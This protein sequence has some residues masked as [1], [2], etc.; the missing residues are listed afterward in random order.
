MAILSRIRELPQTRLDL[1]DWNAHLSSLRTDSKLYTKQMV[2]GLNYVVKGFA[3]SGQ[4]LKQATVNMADATLVIPENSVDFSYF[5]SSVTEPNI[6]I[7]DAQL[8][9]GTRNYVEIQ[10]V[11][12][13]NTPLTKAFWDPDADSGAGAEFNQIV[14]TMTDLGVQIIVSTGG[15]SGSPDRLPLA[16]IDTDN[17]GSI[18]II[19]DRRNLLFRLALPTNLDNNYA[20]GT[21]I[22]PAYLLNLT[23]VSGTFV[24]NEQISIGSETA[25]LT[26]GGTSSI[27]FNSPTG[28]NY[29]IGSAVTGLTS[30]ATGN[31][32]SVVENF[33]G[34]DKNISD[35]KQSDDAIKTEIKSIKG[36]RYWWQDAPT[37]LSGLSAGQNSIIVQASAGSKYAWTGTQL[38][39]TDNS[40]SPLDTDILAKIRLFGQSRNLNLTRQDSAVGSTPITIGDQQVLYITIP[41]SGDATYTGV[42]IGPL[43]YK[44]IDSATFVPNDNTYWIAYRESSKLYMRDYGDLQAG[45]SVD[46]DFG[47]SDQILSAIGA[48]DN[49]DYTSQGRLIKTPGVNRVNVTP[50][51]KSAADTTQ[52]AQQI[53]GLLIRFAGAQIDFT[54]GVVYQADGVTPLGTNF[55]P[56][57]IAANQFRWYSVTAVPGSTN[58]QNE[59]LMTLDVI[60]AD[61]DGSSAA[62]A[63]KA[64]F[65]SGIPLGQ[66]AVQDNGSGGSGTILTIKQSN[67]VQLGAGSGS[68]NGSLL[69]VTFV[70]PLSTTLPTGASVT[71]DG[72][73]GSNGDLVLFTNLLSGNNEIYKL[74]GVG[75]SIV[76]TPTRPFKGQFLPTS[77]D[78]VIATKGNGFA[79]QVGT[80]NGTNW[81]F[82]FTIRRFNGADYVEQSS[83][84]TTSLSNNTTG[85]VFTVT[86]AGSEH[87][88]I[89]YSISRGVNSETGQI[90]INSD[91]TDVTVTKNGPYIGDV[92]TSFSGLITGGNLELNYTTDN[93]GSSATMKFFYERWSDNA[94]GP[95]G[96]PTY[97]GSTTGVTSLNSLAGAINLI[98]GSNITITPSGNNLTIASTGGGGGTPAG[99]DSQVQF[100]SSGSFGADANFRFD[101]A[102]G[103]I[104]QNGLYT[105]ALSGPITVLDNTTGGS[106]FTYNAS[107]YPYAIMEYSISRGS[108][109]FVGTAW[110]VTDGSSATITTLGNPLGGSNGVTLNALF[111]AGNVN[112]VYN[113]TS[114]GFG[115]TFKY[116]MRRWS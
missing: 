53:E 46:V 17:S 43:N 25:T 58:S 103:S 39:I 81:L 98:A 45:E 35:Q 107:S 67:M 29:S 7:T 65:S 80:F 73:A 105:T 18:Q 22:E 42:G 85:N 75:T 116:S 79:E 102:S 95:S 61:T 20:W 9:D 27:S 13:D 51:N 63:T 86:S 115:G 74:S 28:V 71:I 37:S 94:G 60:P 77:G 66:V 47:V 8:Q 93:S 5:I 4:G 56:A 49:A 41:S 23:G 82:N 90:I 30:G 106:L 69:K 113:S 3:V 50:F 33:N 104:L 76:W 91:G 78:Q 12:V 70:D 99:S 16:I 92:N 32:G 68:G 59:F 88:I 48:L 36:T 83:I 64:A 84:F 38:S 44:V 19:L 24:T 87:W 100:N 97:S 11:E 10:L 112:I 72:I 26:A 114:T 14:N 34:V 89:G 57:T 111:S 21:K 55:T 31:V 52:F 108:T 110:I 15:F 54:T 101:T 1:E 40:V 96:V 62:L 109:L 6:T 2:A